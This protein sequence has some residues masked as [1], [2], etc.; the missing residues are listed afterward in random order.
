[1]CKME[2]V[3]DKAAALARVDGDREFLAQLVDVFMGDATARLAGVRAALA[4]HDCAALERAAHSLKGAASSI[5]ATAV[6]QTA[7]RLEALARAGDLAHAGPVCAALEAEMARLQPALAELL[8]EADGR[9]R[10]VD[11]C[12]A[13]TS[14]PR[15]HHERACV[16]V[17]DDNPTVLLATQ[18]AL[19]TAGFDVVTASTGGDG[20]RVAK[21]T[22]PDVIVLDVVLPD[23]S[24]LDVC[25]RIKADPQLAGIP[26][27]LASG[28]QTSS[29]SRAHGLDAGAD[30]YI[31]RPVE[32]QE[33]VAW[34]RAMLRIKTTEAQLRQAQKLEAIGRLA[35]GVAHDFNNQ[36]TV[37]KGYLQFLL[38]KL[39]TDDPRRADAERVDTTVDK[40]TRLVRQLLSFSR[41]QPLDT[42]SLALNELVGE[43]EP[44]LRLL[45]GEQIVLRVHT[46]PGLWRIR[47]DRGRIEQV[48][49]N[50]ASN[51]RDA[52]APT[53][54]TLT[55]ETANVQAHAF[56]SQVVG[57]K[58]E[59]GAYVMLAVS[60]VGPGMPPE[61]R[62]RIFEPFFT[63]KEVGK[64][65]G[66][67][68][69]TVFGI[70]KQHRGY[71]AC[72]STLGEGTTFRIYFPR[73]PHD[74]ATV[75]EAPI[76]AAL[77]ARSMAHQRTVLV[78]EDEGNLRELLV[79]TL[80]ESGY[81]VCGAARAEEALTACNNRSID[82]LVTDIV[83]PGETGPALARRLRQT[84]PRLAVILVSGYSPQALDLAE[85]PGARFLPKPFG[86]D[87]LLRTIS[88][89]LPA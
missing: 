21:A 9:A 64:G 18:R 3:I 30:G 56:E 24:G 55:L 6:A 63:T 83:M 60:D 73:D 20:V 78:V 1:M 12:P 43:M 74:A 29:G 75:T 23:E 85:L 52:L 67:G 69:A 31:V 32:N 19:R 57:G 36:L 65:T 54:G 8:R 53:G 10:T 4:R 71:I 25:Q 41:L 50:L 72:D 38:K 2:P 48:L 68:L 47:A 27:L 81:R 84:Y 82:V 62:E 79:Q 39:S 86:F 15:A 51:A 88:E 76:P 37:I 61:V 35:G 59:P 58:V 45:L 77:A 17:V 26:V 34:V 44:M 14:T 80:E 11:A 70:V 49:M 42:R 89:L 33:L 7:E 28:Q 22:Q 13:E 66:L 87:E 46:A 40:C 5:G 16:L